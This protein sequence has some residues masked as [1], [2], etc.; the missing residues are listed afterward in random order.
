LEDEKGA[1]IADEAEVLYCCK[2]PPSVDGTSPTKAVEVVPDHFDRKWPPSEGLDMQLPT[3]TLAA[4]ETSSL[5]SHSLKDY[6]PLVGRDTIRRISKK[7]D[8]KKRS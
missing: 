4:I 5:G 3:E 6:E 1:L 8:A 2:S 7:A